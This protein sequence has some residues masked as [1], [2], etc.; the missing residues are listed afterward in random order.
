MLTRV[1]ILFGRELTVE[2]LDLIGKFLDDNITED[3]IS[4]AENIEIVEDEQ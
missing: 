4:V 1:E 2:E 3:W